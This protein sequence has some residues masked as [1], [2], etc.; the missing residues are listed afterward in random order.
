[1]AQLRRR[2]Q[3]RPPRY[4][5]ELRRA[6]RARRNKPY[7]EVSRIAPW[8]HSQIRWFTPPPEKA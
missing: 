3:L 4:V 6:Q 7:P 2:A 1:M 8:E 5:E